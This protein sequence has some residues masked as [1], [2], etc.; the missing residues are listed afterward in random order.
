MN[1]PCF[2]ETSVGLCDAS[3]KLRVPS[4]SEME[5]YCFRTAFRYCPFFTGEALLKISAKVF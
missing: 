3:K 4:I 5:I 1:C 2:K